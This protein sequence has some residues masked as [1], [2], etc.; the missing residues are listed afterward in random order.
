LRPLLFG[1]IAFIGIVT[2]AGCIGSQP[3]G[4]APTAAIA[5]V[6]VAEPEV[7]LPV[8]QVIA[9]SEG[10]AAEYVSEKSCAGCHADA[11]R[12]HA[13]T[14]HADTFRPVSHKRDAAFFRL[15]ESVK[16]EL[17]GGV[18]RPLVAG[19]DLMVEGRQ[20]PNRATSTVTHAIGSGSAG[21]TYLEIHPEGKCLMPRIQLYRQ[22]GKPHWD[23]TPGLQPGVT[24][25]TP[26][27]AIIP[28]DELPECLSCHSTVLSISAAKVDYRKSIFNIGCQRC[29]GPAREHLRQV[30]QRPLP[31]A[32]A[33]ASLGMPRLGSLNAAQTTKLCETCHR[34]L[35]PIPKDETPATLARL[36][37]RALGMSTCFLKG[38]R[39]RLSC[40]SCHRPHSARETNPAVYERTC[41]GCHGQPQQ[42][43]VN[44]PVDQRKGCVGCHMG[45]E[46]LTVFGKSEYTNHWIRKRPTPIWRDAR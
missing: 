32:T 36:Q 43:A 35:T 37:G 29:H 1:T 7:E 28:S 21:I 30:A 18:F 11:V 26:L 33:T 5:P 45:K 8:P 46:V 22:K 44:C 24:P 27:G 12:D 31:T 3:N 41:K 20:G 10:K 6:A 17:T 25:P 38:D 13:R 4:P 40:M 14:P 23:W 42:T 39:E 16:D 19:K 9:V 15:P 2:V 34:G